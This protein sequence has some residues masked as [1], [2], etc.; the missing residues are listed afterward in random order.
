MLLFVDLDHFK[1]LNDR[2]GHNIGDACLVAV[3][4]TLVVRSR[5]TDLVARIGGDEFGVLAFGRSSREALQ[6]TEGLCAAIANLR[7]EEAPRGVSVSVSVGAAIR[8][9]GEGKRELMSRADAALYKAK[10]AG[11]GCVSW[12]ADDAPP[13]RPA[14][15]A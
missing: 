9:P 6:L 10:R 3:A 2:F 8:R 13:Q 15:A 4:N 7:L 11:R 14:S 12:A 5:P 1:Q